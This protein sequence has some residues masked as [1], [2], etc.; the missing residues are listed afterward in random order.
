MIRFLSR[1]CAC[2]LLLLSV[3]AMEL[4]SKERSTATN[5]A[6]SLAAVG[7]AALAASEMS[8]SQRKA[9]KKRLKKNLLRENTGTEAPGERRSRVAVERR[10]AEMEVGNM[11]RC[12]A[13]DQ[14]EAEEKGSKIASERAA[15][16]RKHAKVAKAA[17]RADKSAAKRADKAAQ[18]AREAQIAKQGEERRQ[19]PHKRPLLHMYSINMLILTPVLYPPTHQAYLK[20]CRW[21]LLLKERRILLADASLLND[22]GSVPIFQG[23]LLRVS[24]CVFHDFLFVVQLFRVVVVKFFDLDSF[25]EILGSLELMLAVIPWLKLTKSQLRHLIHDIF[26]PPQIGLFFRICPGLLAWNHLLPSKRAAVLGT[27]F[28]IAGDSALRRALIYDSLPRALRTTDHFKWFLQI[29]PN[30]S[31]IHEFSKMSL[32]SWDNFFGTFSQV[33]FNDDEKVRLLYTFTGGLSFGCG[34]FL[35]KIL[36]LNKPIMMMYL[37][38]HS[39]IDPRDVCLPYRFVYDLDVAF[40]LLEKCKS[41]P[42]VYF[43]FDLRDKIDLAQLAVQRF[44]GESYKD[45][46]CRVRAQPSILTA[47]IERDAALPTRSN[48]PTLEYA[49][50]EHRSDR[51]VVLAVVKNH[52]TAL[53]FASN[54]LRADWE[55]CAAAICNSTDAFQFMSDEVKEAFRRDYTFTSD[56]IKKNNELLKFGTDVVR[57]DFDVVRIAISKNGLNM[58]FASEALKHDIGLCIHAV[59][60]NPQAF[61]HLPLVMKRMGSILDAA[62]FPSRVPN[63]EKEMA[64][65]DFDTYTLLRTYYVKKESAERDRVELQKRPFELKVLASFLEEVALAEVA[66]D[67]PYSYPTHVRCIEEIPEKLRRNSRVIC[68]LAISDRVIISMES[69]HAGQFTAVEITTD[70][71]LMASILCCLAF[72]EENKTLYG[73]LLS[74]VCAM[75]EIIGDLDFICDFLGSWPRW[76]G[77]SLCSD[78]LF[79]RLILRLSPRLLANT[80]VALTVMQQFAHPNFSVKVIDQLLEAEILPKSDNYPILTAALKR[81]A[82]VLVIADDSLKLEPWFLFSGLL[83]ETIMVF[84]EQ[85]SLLTDANA[86]FIVEAIRRTTSRKHG[87]RDLLLPRLGRN[88]NKRRDIVLAVISTSCCPSEYEYALPMFRGDPEIFRVA[89]GKFSVH[90]IIQ[91]VPLQAM[92]NFDFVAK[93][94]DL[95]DLDDLRHLSPALPEYSEIARR[96]TTRPFLSLCVRDAWNNAAALFLKRVHDY[97]KRS[98]KPV[99]EVRDYRRGSKLTFDVSFDGASIDDDSESEEA[100]I[101]DDSDNHSDG[102]HEQDARARDHEEDENFFANHAWKEFAS[103]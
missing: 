66:W 15:T 65:F 63:W 33:Y 60:Q 89:A 26:Q 79:L 8:K 17:K 83:N 96:L 47:S 24:K 94:L 34:G 25:V 14:K 82:S 13:A 103:P 7:V 32:K 12:A 90:R 77:W 42:T 53:Q 62:D 20:I 78:S 64:S 31:E 86:G 88:L 49:S 100:E 72:C 55:V 21:Y 2:V 74:D 98:K 1:V 73:P 67:H 3:D 44:G 76:E 18:T 81:N 29:P 37:K 48:H 91:H 68:S 5:A 92:S 75:A 4:G 36:Q 97:Q 38:S 95:L 45:L 43:S 27:V 16:A 101:E 41:S 57:G 6:A 19:V 52:G 9:W 35:P 30:D 39:E 28:S 70:K 59:I 50:I 54:A 99:D 102:V 69:L 40:A 51:A 71:H 84:A 93:I 22:E 46:S 58:Q 87:L 56:C 10:A 80:Q 11:L 61:K 85:N 23:L